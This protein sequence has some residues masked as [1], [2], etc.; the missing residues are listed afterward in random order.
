MFALE[1]EPEP[2][3]QKPKATMEHLRFEAV[4]IVERK[5]ADGWTSEERDVVVRVG[6]GG[7]VIQDTEEP[8]DLLAYFPASA[9][10]EAAESTCEARHLI[11]SRALRSLLVEQSLL[12]RQPGADKDMR[13][14][15]GT[16]LRRCGRPEGRGE[17]SQE[18]DIA[19]RRP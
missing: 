12:R 7:V 13:G 6:V 1:P 8:P 4:Q 17:R 18:H 15:D 14:D 16:R 10:V 19:R 3:V 11:E 2:R 5:D 9:I